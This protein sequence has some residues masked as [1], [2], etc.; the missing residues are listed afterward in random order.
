[1]PTEPKEDELWECSAILVSCDTPEEIMDQDEKWEGEV[2]GEQRSSAVVSLAPSESPESQQAVPAPAS[3]P[4]S[5]DD[6]A[7]IDLFGEESDGEF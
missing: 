7:S 2:R 6:V 4:E 5:G 3:D 1:M